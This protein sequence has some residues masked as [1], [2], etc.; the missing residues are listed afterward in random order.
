MWWIIVSWTLERNLSELLIK[1]Q[2]LFSIKCIWKYRLQN[3]GFCPASITHDPGSNGICPF[4]IFF[5]PCMTLTKCRWHGDVKPYE[6]VFRLLVTSLWRYNEVMC[7]LGIM[8][9]WMTILWPT[10][11][12]TEIL[13]NFD[14]IFYRR[15]LH[16][17][18]GIP[19]MSIPVL[20]M[21]CS[22]ASPGHQNSW[23][24]LH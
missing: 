9:G 5:R 24:S 14:E 22:L 16:R 6:R 7:P 15:W 20:L 11:N 12:D 3:G 2:K 21:P 19:A 23:F 10:M 1:I 17:Q 13:L 18:Y 4:H 8:S